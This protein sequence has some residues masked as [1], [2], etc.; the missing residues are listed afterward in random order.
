VQGPVGA[1]TTRF[2]E[3]TGARLGTT[4]DRIEARRGSRT[5][6]QAATIDPS[7][8]ATQYLSVVDANDP[9]AT[10]GGA[11]AS[12]FL[13]PYAPLTLGAQRV[14]SAGFGLVPGGDGTSQGNGIR[15]LISTPGACAP[16]AC[17]I[18]R[19]ATDGT[20]AT[21]PVLAPD[22]STVFTATTAGTVYA[23]DAAT[24]A[25]RWTAAV[26]SP[27]DQLPALANGFA[28]AC[29]Q[30]GRAKGYRRWDT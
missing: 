10:W 18:W 13:A 21:P 29:A 28:S 20:A 4:S 14:Y 12:G 5:L 3:I 19:L 25:L 11:Y 2:D 24:G 8:N 1:T 30:R 16:F 23:V 17:P 26:G 7:L 6:G 15:A 27:V 22:E 9:S